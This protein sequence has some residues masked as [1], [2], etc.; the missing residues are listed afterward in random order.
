VIAT[1]VGLDWK[2]GKPFRN[3]RPARITK[4]V[5]DSLRRLRTDV[6][7]VFQVH[8]PDATVPLDDTAE[9]WRGSIAPARSTPSA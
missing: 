9:R 1:K 6:I 7:D 5:E 2:N 8:W 3:S 4:E